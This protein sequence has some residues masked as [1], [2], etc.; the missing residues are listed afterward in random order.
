M[1]CAVYCLV[2]H[3]AEL[4]PLVERL[5]EA[6]I[7]SRDIAVVSRRHWQAAK[8][9][10]SSLPPIYSLSS[11]LL[12]VPIASAALWWEWARSSCRFPGEAMPTGGQPSGSAA[13]IISLDAYGEKRRKLSRP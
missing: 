13:V 2:S 9:S 7:E 8:S 3:P 12:S 11:F 10:P 5:K 1:P 6:G 4:D